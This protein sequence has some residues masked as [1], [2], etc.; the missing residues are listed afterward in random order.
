MSR[1]NS[2]SGQER[3]TCVFLSLLWGNKKADPTQMSPGQLRKT[4]RLL[5]AAG[6]LEA[7]MS[8]VRDTQFIGDM[9]N[10]KVI[11]VNGKTKN[12]V[13]ST[14][15]ISSGEFKPKSSSS[16][17]T[18]EAAVVYV[19]NFV[20]TLKAELNKLELKAEER[21]ARRQARIDEMLG[22][23]LIE[24]KQGNLPVAL[25]LDLEQVKV[26]AEDEQILGEADA[27]TE[28]IWRQSGMPSEAS[29]SLSAESFAN[30][31][32]IFVNAEER[33]T[34]CGISL[35]EYASKKLACFGWWS[36]N[37]SG[38]LDIRCP[39]D[40][41]QLVEHGLMFNRLNEVVCQDGFR[42]SVQAGYVD[43][44]GM[45]Y[46]SSRDGYRFT[47]VEI[48]FPSAEDPM[49]LPYKQVCGEVYAYVP[50][51]VVAMI[52]AKHGGVVEGQLPVGVPNLESLKVEV[53]KRPLNACSSQEVMA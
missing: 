24:K 6:G 45:R 23:D 1:P 31:L 10:E 38:N 17:L 8:H 14:T 30:S 29:T 4:S 43:C 47:E 53:F 9:M 13:L 15:H 52:V 51:S 27:L 50:V 19:G 37:E 48:A 16:C 36:G 7:V 21:E 11:T 22:K 33:D 35:K 3:K 26:Q 49:L 20:N 32:C 40:V 2:A 44:F 34:V 42:M 28:A 12:V 18:K 25:R 5:A 46:S 39:D 41:D